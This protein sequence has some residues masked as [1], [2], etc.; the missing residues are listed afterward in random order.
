MEERSWFRRIAARANYLAADRP[1]IQFAVKEICQGMA[2]PTR[3]HWEKMNTLAR[4]LKSV[5]KMVISLNEVEEEKMKVK[6]GYSDSDLG[7]GV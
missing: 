7:R 3:R 4:Y 1:D 6:E 5:P 2:R